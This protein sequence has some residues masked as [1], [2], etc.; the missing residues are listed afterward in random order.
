MTIKYSSKIDTSNVATK[1]KKRNKKTIIVVSDET[2]DEEEELT[3]EELTT[4]ELTTEELTTEELTTENN[5]KL[6][7]IKTKERKRNKQVKIKNSEIDDIEEYEEKNSIGIRLLKGFS[8]YNHQFEAIEW[9][10]TKELYPRLGINGGILA[11]TMGLG[12]TLTSTSV[13]MSEKNTFPNLVICSKTVA[14]EWKRDIMKFFGSS[15]PFL[16]LHKSTVKNFNTLTYNDISHYKIIITTYET[17]MGVAKKNKVYNKQMVMDRFGRRYGI[18]NSTRPNI[19]D[20]N[21]AIGGMLL[22]KTAWN[23]IICDESH[24]FSN[25]TSST[26]YSIMSLYGE[27]RW[28]L[29]GTPLRNYSFDLYSQ[30]RFCGYDQVLSL[31][32]F[33]YDLYNRHKMFEFILCKNY[34]DAG[35]ILPELIENTVT[36]ELD[37]RE[38]EIYDYYLSATKKIFNGFLVG[39]YNF[40]S[41]LTLFLRLRQICISPYTILDE[42]SRKYKKLNATEEL[43]KDYT[44]SQDVLDKMTDGLATWVKD[45]HGSAGIESAKMKEIIKII[46]NVK[47]GDKTLVFTSFKK[48]ID[49]SALALKIKLPNVKYL[50]LDGDVTGLNREKT[51]DMFKDPTLNYNVMFISYKVGSEGLNLVQA[52]NIIMCENWWTP[53][54]YQQARSRSHRIGQTN[55][56]T[57]WSILI[58]GSIEQKIDDICNEKLKLIDDFLISKKKF[59][60]KLDHTTLGRIIK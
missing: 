44:V 31:K 30:L 19:A 43:K 6:K 48:V 56:V 20:T 33:N 47:E 12:K 10:K 46:K 50:I 2:S 11:L 4:E 28:C 23:R 41:V 60:T 37:D 58:N 5:I 26:F 57:V 38:K 8:I 18:V 32:E 9:M 21:K 40:S 52:N 25:P 13:C 24:R 59:N 14:Y 29:T 39:S 16:Y 55:T 27:K 17:V 15:C 45:K 7:L 53:V 49:V 3:T 22:F 51:L 36:I 54:S 34:K 35:I 1:S 42:S